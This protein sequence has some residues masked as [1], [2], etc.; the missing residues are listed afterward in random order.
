MSKV[1]TV[2]T[3]KTLAV[4]RLIAGAS[5][6]CAVSFALAGGFS[7]AALATED[8]DIAAEVNGGVTSALEMA[9]QEDISLL[10]AAD[11]T[12]VTTWYDASKTEFTISTLGEMN[13]LAQL[14]N[15]GK[16]TFEGK[17]IT[18]SKMTFPMECEFTSI[19]TADHPFQGTFQA[20]GSRLL[21]PVIVYEGATDIG[22]F[23]YAG[24][25]ATIDGINIVGGTL[26][27]TQAT[28]GEKIQYVG[29]IAGE[30]LGTVTNC[31]SSM[32]VSVSSDVAAKLGTAGTM[33]EIGGLVG[34]LGTAM[35]GCSFSGTLSI[36]SAQGVI[37]NTATEEFMRYIAGNIGGLVGRF[38]SETVEG[39]DGAQSI[40]DCT[41]A[42]TLSFNITGSSDKDRFGEQTY[43]ITRCVGGIVGY[44]SGNV[45]GCTNKGLIHTGLGTADAPEKQHGGNCVGGIVGALRGTSLYEA[46][47]SLDSQEVYEPG[48]YVWK[49]SEG[50][51]EPRTISITNCYNEGMVIGLGSVG[52]IS[53]SAGCWT[54]ILGCGNEGYIK[55]CRW[56]KPAPAGI[57]GNT[58]GSVGVCYN[59]G[60]IETI[61][62]AGY[63]AAGIAG[64]LNT[65]NNAATPDNL[66]YDL[67][68]IYSC[69]STGN[70][71]SDQGY[72]SA[73]LVGENN[74]VVHDNLYLKGICVGNNAFDDKSE[75]TGYN[76]KMVEANELKS[77]SAVAKLN[78]LLTT[79]DWSVYFTVGEDGAFPQLNWQE[80]LKKTDINTLGAKARLT[81]NAKYSA[82]NDPVPEISITLSDGTVLYQ[83][84]DFRV[85]PETGARAVTSGSTPYHA[86]I[87]GMGRYEGTLSETVAYGI[88]KGDISTCVIQA[89]ATTYNWEQQTPSW[90]KVVD[91]A[92]NVLDS[93][94]YTVSYP[95]S[96]PDDNK[97][98][99]DG[100]Y[101]DYVNSHSSTYKYDV[102][103]TAT[104]TSNYTGSTTQAVFRIGWASMMYSDTSMGG[105]RM[106]GAK[107]DKVVFGDQEWDFSEASKNTHLI[108]IKYTGSEIKPKVN[109]VTYL[110][111]ELRDG[112]D[113]GLDLYAHPLDYDYKYVYGNPNP[114]ETNDKSGDD[115]TNVTGSD[116]LG[117]MTLRFTA[118]GNFENFSNVFYEIVP[119]SVADDVTVSGVTEV[120]EE[121]A[122]TKITI[123]GTGN[124]EGTKVL[125]VSEAPASPVLTYNGMT[126]VKGTDYTVEAEYLSGVYGFVDRLYEN[127]LGR[128]AD[129]AGM[130]AQVQG[131]KTSGAA[132]ITFN[133]YNSDEFKAKS[134]TMT[135]AEIVE[136][137]YQTMLGRSADEGGLAMWKC[138]LDNGMSAC[139]LAAG[140]AESPEFV[141]VCTG[142][143]VDAG[144]ADWLR[145]NKLESRD[146][147]P[148]V[149][150]FVYRLYTIVL[151]REA[152]VAGLNVQC[153]ALIDGT[154][155]WELAT[156]FFNSQEYINFNKTDTAFVADC[157]K[158]M[159]DR[160]GT[161]AEI[162]AWVARM[163]KEGLTR[164]DVVKGFCQSDE[165]EAICQ[166]CGMTSGMR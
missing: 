82:S 47:C 116:N 79:S 135:N 11:P 35:S 127:V 128:T 53:G 57:V 108:K 55:G 26:E 118:G 24:E 113:A 129:E 46:A 72:R 146:K 148:G 157:Y 22:L 1:A 101:Y 77:S 107:M 9:A 131:I 36:T 132:Q 14:V 153:Q 102:T 19:G 2:A 150:S 109:K 68:E 117:C 88:D 87:V 51:T 62:R 73:A 92:G 133:F 94:E 159:M 67:P 40:E 81:G 158:A 97:A 136:N 125:Y 44:C 34:Y 111:R 93:S 76:N 144:S 166:S 156:R 3:P 124:Y 49:N 52:G 5:V 106:E 32:N 10:A 104:D 56:N 96:T 139:A 20:N 142:Y 54:E 145:A 16:D 61:T 110:G 80:S 39:I 155:C 38:G 6:A 100:K 71:V 30:C 137:V 59:H 114:E 143:G 89:A 162:D 151:D 165:F 83:N 42:G 149:T 17:T 63:Y 91:A 103:V 161:E 98:H 122:T 28:G 27:V 12:P 25:K 154:A 95:M 31:T 58:Y 23:G 85:V 84:S 64:F 134:A 147:V 48:Y 140:F 115:F 75:G 4:K 86:T 119:A 8:S 65:Y 13:G 29:A 69:Y 70:V 78:S 130:A 90:V 50:G 99:E 74:A 18:L 163:A 21:N 7:T 66:V 43:S 126:L 45:S 33:S 105:T 160:E 41:N 164:V 141:N 152:E 123:T 37:S 120:S 15:E 138:Y 60:T 112:T 121:Q